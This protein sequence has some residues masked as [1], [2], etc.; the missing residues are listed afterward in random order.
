[1]KS[2]L[3]ALLIV[4][5][6][7]L[8]CTVSQVQQPTIP[9]E[10]KAFNP[11][12]ATLVGFW[13]IEQKFLGDENE[14]NWVEVAIPQEK[15]KEFKAGAEHCPNETLDSLFNSLNQGITADSGIKFFKMK[16]SIKIE[17]EDGLV[18]IIYPSLSI[19]P[20]PALPSGF[21]PG[22]VCYLHSVDESP[23]YGRIGTIMDI[24]LQGVVFTEEGGILL[25][26]EPQHSYNFSQKGL[27]LTTYYFEKE[28]DIIL[29]TARTILIPATKEEATE[30][31]W[32]YTTG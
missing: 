13:K 19:L 11:E 32:P 5:L 31:G 29:K 17:H 8:G 7:V 6:I 27:E 3:P 24:S 20:S 18:R 23:E 9:E 30:D 15:Y 14:S 2:Y 12:N 28:G 26:K 21:V 16:D 1:M 10:S 22:G 25:V 4:S